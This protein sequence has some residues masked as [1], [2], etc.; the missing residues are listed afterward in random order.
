MKETDVNMNGLLIFEGM[1][2]LRPLLSDTAK[3]KIHRVVIDSSKSRKRAKELSY[4]K[5]KSHEMGFALDFLPH[6][7]FIR[8]CP[9][10]TA[11]GIAAFAEERVIPSLEREHIKENGFYIMLEGIEDPYNFGYALRSAYAAGA[12]GIVVS[13]RNWMSAAPCVCRA[14][15]GASEY[16]DIYSSDAHA[17]DI[18][19]DVGYEVV[20]TGVKNAESIYETSLKTPIFLIIGGE[21]R[22]ISASTLEKC[23]RTVRLEYGR[24]DCRI[25]LSAA[26]AA[27]V[28]AFEVMKANKY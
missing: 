4:I 22:G 25:A 19:H 1:P 26:S 18:F 12:D 3:R 17:P 15:A 23:D 11:G 28:L 16:L 7:E 8:L 24:D 20:A 10:D 6:E 5:A 27:A 2:S 9:G 21:R 14:S 13:E